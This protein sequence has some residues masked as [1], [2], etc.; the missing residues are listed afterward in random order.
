MGQGK[1]QVKSN[2]RLE[3][4]QGF[5]Y[6]FFFIKTYNYL[7]KNSIDNS[8][9]FAIKIEFFQYTRQGWTLQLK[10]VMIIMRYSL[11]FKCQL[12]TLPPS[13]YFFCKNVLGDEMAM[14][15]FAHFKKRI[16]FSH[17]HMYVKDG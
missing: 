9:S 13:T 1:L 8:T 15:I 12:L 10:I 17:L 6:K 7:K 3:I 2:L 14:Y 16:M 4:F 5:H 11:E